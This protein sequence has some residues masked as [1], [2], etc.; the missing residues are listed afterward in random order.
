MKCTLLPQRWTTLGKIL[1]P[2]AAAVPIALTLTA[3]GGSNGLAAPTPIVTRT[4]TAS[5]SASAK[6]SAKAVA[7]AAAP[8]LLVVPAVGYSG[9]EPQ[10]I[11]FSGDA[12]N[13]VIQISWSSWTATR[14]V[15]TGTSNI[16]GC[17]PDCAQGTETPVTATITLSDPVNGKFTAIDEFREGAND[18]GWPL[19]AGQVDPSG[20]VPSATPAAVPSV[21]PATP[22]VGLAADV[23]NQANP[24]T[25]ATI[26]AATI[27]AMC[28]SATRPLYQM[29]ATTY[30][31]DCGSWAALNGITTVP[32]SQWLQ[33]GIWT[34]A[35][36]E[37][38]LSDGTVVQI[39][40]E[41]T[42]AGIIAVVWPSGEVSGSSS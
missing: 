8:A 2:A 10:Y 36:G 26:Q 17:V 30:D 1:I 22:Q 18:T 31:P 27:G 33:P 15:G 19:G 34:C 38:T 20:S 35:L 3:C 4:V 11:A 32:L 24:T 5:P 16:E 14:A 40:A 12:G 9:I 29:N 41:R 23:L 42:D 28:S 21:A 7:V 39:G 13:V 25:G 37:A 6:Q